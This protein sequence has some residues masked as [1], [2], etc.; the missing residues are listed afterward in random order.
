MKHSPNVVRMRDFAYVMRHLQTYPHHTQCVFQPRP[1][2]F[3][4]GVL[5]YGEIPCWI[6]SADSDPWDII[7]PTNVKLKV[8][9]PYTIA[10]VIGVFVLEDGNHKIA[11]HIDGVPQCE[12]KHERAYIEQF[13]KGYTKFTNIKGQ[14]VYM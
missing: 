14:F 12:K 6:N 1:T 9:V 2:K 3:K 13:C 8:N 4:F 10:H 7:A 5:N 11:V